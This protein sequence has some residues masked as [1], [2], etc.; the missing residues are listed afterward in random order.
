MCRTRWAERHVAYS[1]FYQ[2]YVFVVQS[3]EIIAYGMHS[4]KC[5]SDF[6]GCWDTNTKLT[7]SSLLPSIT[8]FDFIM[9][10][11]VVYQMLSHVAGITKQLQ[12]TTIDIL[13]AIGMV[14]YLHA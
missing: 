5:A 14:S 9:T 3:L 11:M 10:F 1:H 13:E 6:V 7:A 12:S 8:S 4:D 2:S